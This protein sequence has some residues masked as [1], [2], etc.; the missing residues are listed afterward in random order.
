MLTFAFSLLG[1]S[2]FSGI[3]T[4][5]GSDTNLKCKQCILNLNR[6]IILQLKRRTTFSEMLC[7]LEWGRF[8]IP[9]K[10]LILLMICEIKN[11]FMIRKYLWSKCVWDHKYYFLLTVKILIF[12]C[13]K[14]LTISNRILF[15]KSELHALWE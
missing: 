3:A 11:Y 8:W 6:Y 1:G 7:H 2:I 14:T 5:R 9:G 15:K 13:P 12:L 4:D 10:K